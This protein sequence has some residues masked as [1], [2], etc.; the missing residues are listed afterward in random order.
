MREKVAAGLFG[1]R[2]VT[3]EKCNAVARSSILSS[4]QHHND[5]RPTTSLNLV[6]SPIVHEIQHLFYDVFGVDTECTELAI[7]W[8]R[9]QWEGIGRAAESA[10][11]GTD[12]SKMRA[13]FR[14]ELTVSHKSRQAVKAAARAVPV[15]SVCVEPLKIR[16][17]ATCRPSIVGMME[18]SQKM[19]GVI[20]TVASRTMQLVSSRVESRKSLG[21]PDDVGASC[22]LMLTT[23]LFPETSARPQTR[24]PL[25]CEGSFLIPEKKRPVLPSNLISGNFAPAPMATTQSK[26][27]WEAKGLKFTS[28]EPIRIERELLCRFQGG[29]PSK[30]LLRFTMQRPS[31][32]IECAVGHV[33]DN[34]NE[35]QETMEGNTNEVQEFRLGENKDEIQ[36]LWTKEERNE[37]EERWVEVNMIEEQEVGVEKNIHEVQESLESMSAADSLIKSSVEYVSMEILAAPSLDPIDSY[38]DSDSADEDA[39][40]DVSIERA[41]AGVISSGA[42]SDEKAGYGNVSIGILAAVGIG[43]SFLIGINRR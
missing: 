39:D 31:Q 30:P 21:P 13:I 11:S 7:R 41:D 42:C 25:P 29:F 3:A 34:K 28:L 33:E 40:Y 14:A 23:A 36:E 17:P 10:I 15:E 24:L 32:A 22:R 12:P 35:E 19:R 9:D 6:L 27:C 5:T 4:S 18:P 2:D 26:T 38:S 43:A 8:V 20:M 1:Q 37:G 16:I